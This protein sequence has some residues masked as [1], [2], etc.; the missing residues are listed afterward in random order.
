MQA[1]ST[2]RA[3]GMRIPSGGTLVVGREQDCMGGCFDSAPGAAGDV[4]QR[5]QL[6]YGA[7]DFTGVIDELRIWKTVRSQEQVQQVCQQLDH[8]CLILSW[9]VLQEHACYQACS[10]PMGVRSCAATALQPSYGWLTT[11]AA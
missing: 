5:Y 2:V 10:K 9:L 4:Q 7:Q 6:E 1:W 11:E 8:A 3:Q